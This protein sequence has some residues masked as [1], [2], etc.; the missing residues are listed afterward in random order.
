MHNLNALKSALDNAERSIRQAKQLLEQLEGGRSSNQTSHPSLPP[1]PAVPKD[2]RPG[3]I[4]IYDGEKIT[5]PAGEAYP[6]PGNYASKSLLVIGDSL[7]MYEE[8]GE[9]RFKQVEHVKRHKTTG[10]L[11]KKDGKF[12]AITPEGSY[13]VLSESIVHFKGEVGDEVV[14]YLPAGNLTAP[15]GA[16]ETIHKKTAKT[17]EE[18]QE[19]ET[20]TARREKYEPEITTKEMVDKMISKVDKFK[21]ENPQ[22]ATKQPDQSD[23]KSVVDTKAEKPKE[24][25]SKEEVKKEAAKSAPKV[26]EAKV[27][28][29]KEPPKKVE[30]PKKEEAPKVEA[31]QTVE[32]VASS[33]EELS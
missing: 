21:E 24:V 20:A 23:H 29:K 5:T 31:N 17:E 28:A 33:E 16:I 14:L 3:V 8:N 2:D 18:A 25:P 12:R 15:Y 7:K 19:E 30:E 27:E 10:L 32:G 4:G 22:L 13:K 6:V 11:V 1:H 26:A 9:K